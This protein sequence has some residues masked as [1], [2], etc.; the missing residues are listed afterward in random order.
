MGCALSAPVELI[1]VQRQ[2]T[3]HFRCAVAEMQ[4][5]RV[6]HEADLEHLCTRRDQ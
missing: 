4:G 3:E 5:W 1:R 6:G 2:G